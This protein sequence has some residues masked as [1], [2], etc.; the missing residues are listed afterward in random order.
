M[1][2]VTEPSLGDWL[3]RLNALDPTRIELGLTRVRPVA[4]ALGVLNP[5]VQVVT[6][7][8][9]NGKGSTLALAESIALADGR[10]VGCYTS[11]AYSAF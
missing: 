10:R 2:V 6:V 11:L 7:A 4:E 3:E 5:Q 9:T 8:G 1:T